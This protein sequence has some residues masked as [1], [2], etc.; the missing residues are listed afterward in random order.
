MSKTCFVELKSILIAKSIY[1]TEDSDYL[2]TT[3]SNTGLEIS[4]GNL[5]HFDN[6]AGGVGAMHALFSGYISNLTSKLIP[7]FF[8]QNHQNPSHIMNWGVFDRNPDVA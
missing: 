5:K 6:D 8:V 4:L 7:S 3:P 1:C 2:E